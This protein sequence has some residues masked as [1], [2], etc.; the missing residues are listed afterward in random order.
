MAGLLNWGDEQP[1]VT[2]RRPSNISNG[3][4][5]NDGSQRRRGGDDGMNDGDQPY[6]GHHER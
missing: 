2:T 5:A 6:G 4:K 3:R 1:E